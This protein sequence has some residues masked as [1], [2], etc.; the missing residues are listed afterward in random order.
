M[1]IIHANVFYR[2]EIYMTAG[3]V[4]TLYGAHMLRLFDNG[5]HTDITPLLHPPGRH[6][7]YRRPG[8]T[9]TGMWNEAWALACVTGA[10]YCAVLNNDITVEPD[11]LTRL[12]DILDSR[13]DLW[14][15]APDPTDTRGPG[16]VRDVTGGGVGPDGGMPGW[17]FMVRCEAH[18]HGLD[19]LADPQFRWWYG[20]DDLA[21]TVEQLGGRV[22]VVRGL[23]C[24]H[25]TSTT[26]N[27]HPELHRT[28]VED[29]LKFKAKWGR[30]R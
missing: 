5:S 8:A 30:S 14:I 4:N 1:S 3:L 7:V 25:K 22:G 27:A 18:E 28:A 21:A 19:R 23:F 11:F 16:L 17:A 24:E 13:P 29:G 20:D 12:A 9:L 15:A 10:D 6:T 2:D 26:W